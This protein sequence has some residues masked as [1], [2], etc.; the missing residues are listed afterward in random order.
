MTR[1][2]GPLNRGPTPIPFRF[3]GSACMT[4]V[5]NVIIHYSL[6]ENYENVKNRKMKMK[7]GKER[8]KEKQGRDRA[9]KIQVR[10]TLTALS[11]LYFVLI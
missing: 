5:G 10:K 6:A 2:T 7:S 1:A 9:C 8:E 4:I 3:S 11:F